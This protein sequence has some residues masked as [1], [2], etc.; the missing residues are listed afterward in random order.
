MPFTDER[1]TVLGLIQNIEQAV[2]IFGE[3]VIRLRRYCRTNA[4]AKTVLSPVMIDARVGEHIAAQNMRSRTPGLQRT[5]SP[6]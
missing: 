2:L 5:A 1:S 6:D 3:P 4:G